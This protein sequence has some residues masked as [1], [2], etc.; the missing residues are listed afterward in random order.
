MSRY[1]I[2]DVQGCYEELR[3]LLVDASAGLNPSEREVI[4]L[5]LRQGLDA[6]EVAACAST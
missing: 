1:A 3:A 2:G 5:Q 6:T 4:E